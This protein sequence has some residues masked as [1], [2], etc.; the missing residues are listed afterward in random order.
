M[1]LAAAAHLG[2]G[3]QPRA[4]GRA[5]GAAAEVSSVQVARTLLVTVGAPLAAGLA[6][7]RMLGKTAVAASRLAERVGAALLAV[8]AV[9]L[10]AFSWPAI[11]LLLHDG[12]LLAVVATT[13]FALGVGQLLGGRDEN[14][15]PALALAASMRHPGVAMAIA[16]A[17][18]PAQTREIAAALILSLLVAA[19]ARAIY[20]AW[21]RRRAPAA[22]RL[23][24]ER[25]A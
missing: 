6:L 19:V 3:P 20:L 24:S 25:A 1:A 16:T 12:A 8:G 13:V 17:S 14:A 22:D 15:R 4:H 7:R 18:F 2:P 23:P 9:L 21:A 5:L 10:I 11:T